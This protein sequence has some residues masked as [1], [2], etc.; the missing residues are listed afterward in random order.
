MIGPGEVVG[1]LA[2]IDHLPRTATVTATGSKR[3]LVL[4]PASFAAMIENSTITRRILTTETKRLRTTMTGGVDPFSWTRGY[5]ATVFS[6][7]MG[8][9]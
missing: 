8:L 7:C 9:W 3:A 2:L 1:E 5:D 4:D 6:N